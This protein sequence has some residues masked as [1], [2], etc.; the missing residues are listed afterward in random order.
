MSGIV[1]LLKINLQIYGRFEF[2]LL[3][4][5]L[6]NQLIEKF[7]FY[8]PVIHS[9]LDDVL[10]IPITLSVTK[11]IMYF[12]HNPTYKS[13]Y[14][15]LQVGIVVVMFSLYFEWYLPLVYTIHY[16]DFIDI[17]CYAFGGVYYLEYIQ[18][19]RKLN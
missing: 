2:L 15:S 16:R 9:Y 6:F 7:G 3:L 4:I 19:T 12:L 14:T 11:Y 17:I 10:A 8:I 5:F 18:N 1:S 13:L